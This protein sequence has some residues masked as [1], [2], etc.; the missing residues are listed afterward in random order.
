VSG[1][2]KSTRSKV[3]LKRFVNVAGGRK[4]ENGEGQMS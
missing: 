2:S 3:E 4:D 1:H